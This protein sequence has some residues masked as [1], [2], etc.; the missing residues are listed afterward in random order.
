LVLAQRR[1]A[2]SANPAVARPRVPSRLVDAFGEELPFA[3]TAEQSAVAEVLERELS[4]EHPM[5]RLLQGEVG[6]GKT[7]VALRAMLQVVDAGGQAALLAPT[8]VLAAQHEQ[9]ILDLLGPL[10]RAGQLGGDEQATKLT[11][12]TGSMS[13]PMRRAALLDAASGAAG[14]VIGTHALIQDHVQFADLGLVVVDEQ[15]RFGVEQRDALRSKASAPPHMLVMTATPIPRTVAMTVFGDLEVSELRELPQGRKDV[16]STVVP[17]LERPAWVER[18]WQRVREQAAQNRQIYVV[19]PRI[20]EGDEVDDAGAPSDDDPT[21]SASVLAT[22]GELSANQLAGLRVGLMHGRLPPEEKS[23]VMA[24]FAAGALD[25]LVS[26]TVIEVGVNVPNA[27]MMVIMDADRFG[28]SQLHQ[29]RGRI[30][31]GEHPG[32]CLMLTQMPSGHPALQR[33]DEVAS[34]RDG[35]ALAEVD[36]RQ[37]REGDVLGAAQSGRKSQLK[38]LSLLKDEELIRLARVEAQEVI[39]ADPTLKNH[40]QLQEFLWDSFDSER[41]E[42]LHKS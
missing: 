18:V 42:Y 38:L 21:R 32:L 27:T 16:T 15:H 36:L 17:V 35:F 31:R 19:C 39:D 2:I 41:T 3:F 6:S 33:L 11:L 40:Q 20:G 5:Q 28:V 14:I 8:E 7:V 26:T 4:G 9:T 23:R 30:G 13:A 24:D 1:H 25:V 34:T 22:Y 10:A 37:R 12:L 29:L